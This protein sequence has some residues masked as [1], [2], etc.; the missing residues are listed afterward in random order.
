MAM[1]KSI[2]HPFR[3]NQTLTSAYVRMKDFGFTLLGE[4]Q[5]RIG[6][7][8]YK[9]KQARDDGL[10]PYPLPQGETDVM[11]ADGTLAIE[12]SGLNAIA[13][14]EV[15][16]HPEIAGLTQSEHGF[17]KAFEDAYGETHPE[18]LFAPASMLANMIEKKLDIQ[19]FVWACEADYL[20]GAPALG[21]SMIYHREGEGFDAFLTAFD[22]NNKGRKALYVESKKDAKYSDVED[23]V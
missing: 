1:T 20:A 14:K 11:I 8:V 22:A 15:L 12:V 19:L 23:D 13:L 6:F 5:G 4:R 16:S 2:N 17:I 3:K 9:D 7:A 21:G 10:M 18:A